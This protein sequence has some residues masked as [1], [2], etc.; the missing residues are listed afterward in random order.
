MSDMIPLRSKDTV[1]FHC[2]RC[3]ACCRNIKDTIMVEPI[4]A[5][6]LARFFHGRSGYS[7]IRG[8]EG[9]YSWFTHISTLEGIFPIYLM[10]ATGP[11]GA[12]TFLENGR[13]S[14][15]EARPRVCRLY[16]FTAFPGT[17]GRDFVFYQCMDGH[18]GHFSGGRAVVKDWMYENF[19]REDRASLTEVSDVI[20]RL[21]RLL[22]AL[23]PAQRKRRYYQVLYYYYFHYDLEQPFLPQYRKN[24]ETLCGEL[25]SELSGSEELPCTC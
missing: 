19:T 6:R 22:K 17:R 21:G 20:P 1:P 14:V 15:Y 10:N 24:V 25:Q 2:G 3:A 18:A 5:L 16:P 7:Q 11:E 23:S 9:V 8:V 13:C 12:C 4:D